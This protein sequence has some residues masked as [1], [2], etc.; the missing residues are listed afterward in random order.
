MPEKSKAATEK[1]I[2]QPR[3]WQRKDGTAAAYN[4][5]KYGKGAEMQFR[6]NM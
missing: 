5:D 6:N 1:G 3:E 2:T 4:V